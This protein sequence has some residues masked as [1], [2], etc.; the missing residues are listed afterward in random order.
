MIATQRRNSIFFFVASAWNSELDGTGRDRRR[1]LDRR[2][3]NRT[4]RADDSAA[5]SD[6]CA[7]RSKAKKA[8]TG[9]KS[10]IQHCV[11]RISEPPL[12]RGQ[13]EQSVNARHQVGQR[14]SR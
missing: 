10:S 11:P 3:N 9:Q 7:A 5:N 6:G 1:G 4:G 12:W 8:Q 2:A 14:T 13:A